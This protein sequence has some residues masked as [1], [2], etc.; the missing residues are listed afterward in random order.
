MENLFNV[1]EWLFIICDEPPTVKCFNLFQK[2][3]NAWEAKEGSSDGEGWSPSTALEAVNGKMFNIYEWLYIICDELPTMTCF[4]LFQKKLN[5]LEADRPGES[6]WWL[7]I[8][9]NNVRGR[10]W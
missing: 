10:Q 1:Y 2:K 5:A 8:T 4:N 7:T 6:G 3:L 9:I